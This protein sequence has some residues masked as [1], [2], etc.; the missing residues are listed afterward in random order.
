MNI[1]DELKNEHKTQRSLINTLLRSEGESNE[2]KSVFNQLKIELVA[3]A[4]CEER[5]FYGPLLNRDI[6]Q[7]KARHSIS[8]HKD[9]DD[10]IGIL[11]ET[12]MSSP[13]WM[14]YFKQLRELVFHHLDEEENQIFQVAGKALN[15]NEKT[16]LATEYREMMNREREQ[17]K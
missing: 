2:R 9:I 7:K 17:L 3:H 14:T 4:N 8:E 6:T 12:E 13:A 15:E 16:S 11:D 5:F 1:F 10:K